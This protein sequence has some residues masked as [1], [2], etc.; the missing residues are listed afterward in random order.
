[1]ERI[2]TP[3]TART[4]VTAALL[5]VAA[6]AAAAVPSGAPAADGPTTRASTAPRF[7]VRALSARFDDPVWVGSAGDGT[8]ALLV[9]E[10]GGLVWRVEGASKVRFLDLRPVIATGG[11]QG[12][13][14][15]AV[16][17]DF[18][19]S[20][21]IFAYFTRALDGAGQVRSF[22]VRAGE[23]VARSARVVITVP[24]AP[25][26]ETNHNGGTVWSRADGTLLLSVGDGGG[27]GDPA[28]NAQRLDRLT[29]KV[30]RIRPRASG[31][32]SVP[33]DNPFVAR[34]GAREEIWALGLRNPWR[35][36]IDGPTGDV[37][38]ADVG[39]G[40]VEEVDRVPAG[41]PAGANFGWNRMEGTRVFER[42]TALTSG[43]RYVGPRTQYTHADGRCSITGGLVYR[44]P[45]VALR[46]WY[47]YADFCDDQLV[48]FRHL[49]SRTVARA[50]VRGIVHIGAGARGEAFV[51]SQSTD[52]VYRVVAG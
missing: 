15:M 25:P 40:D 51:A 42:G 29:G 27:G 11:E 20:G 16:A 21:R 23:V 3:R 39:Q 49:G 14:S 10:Q 18:R 34:P 1:M 19:T 46:G 30:L 37:W 52:R 9:A 28:G 12:L 5:V 35:L 7:A 41:A 8:T 38:I 33:A 24:L 26:T 36:S 50:A 6:A 2:R 44:G 45:L 47:L 32:Y 43:T 22:R 4:L 31:G 48:A 13:L 17:S